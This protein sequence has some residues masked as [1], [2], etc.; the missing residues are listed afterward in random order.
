MDPAFLAVLSLGTANG[1]KH[2]RLLG[3]RE[4]HDDFAAISAKSEGQLVIWLDRRCRLIH[5]AKPKNVI[6]G[7]AETG[8]RQY[9]LS[10]RS[11]N[12]NELTANL[13]DHFHFAF[14]LGEPSDRLEHVPCVGNYADCFLGE[15]KLAQVKMRLQIL[16]AAYQMV[17]Y[18]VGMEN[19]AVVPGRD[20]EQSPQASPVSNVRASVSQ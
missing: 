17:A 16:Q 10:L 4:A 8:A 12:L 2:V 9:F 13:D 5:F 19:T 3:A 15:M 6:H 11:R 1:L 7:A 14:G 18:I 20:P